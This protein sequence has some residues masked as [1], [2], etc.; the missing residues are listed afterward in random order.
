M[1]T[2]IKTL[3]TKLGVEYGFNPDDAWSKVVEDW[4]SVP[5]VARKVLLPWCGEVNSTNC[6]GIRVNHGLYT[7]C[8]G[9]QELGDYCKTCAKSASSN[10]GEPKYGRVTDRSKED[11]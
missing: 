4:L 11:Y 2:R 1:E 5:P 6:M 3:I 10:G 7:Q 8:A 9:K